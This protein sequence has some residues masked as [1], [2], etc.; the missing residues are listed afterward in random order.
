MRRPL[1]VVAAL[2]CACG[3]SSTSDLPSDDAASDGASDGASDTSIGGDAAPDAGGDG[4]GDGGA[5]GWPTTYTPPTEAT[6][7]STLVAGH[8]RLVVRDADLATIKASLTDPVAKG[9]YT[10]LVARGDA[11]LTAPVSERVLVGPR[12]LAVSREVLKRTYTLALLHRLTGDAKYLDRA[13]KELVHVAGFSD[14]NPSHFLD[15]AEMSYAFAIGYD[16]LHGSLSPA[17]RKTIADALVTKGLAE[18]KKAY[19]AK[20]W[21]T[22]DPFNWNLVCHGGLTAGALAVADEQPALA[23]FLLTRA[24]ANTP[25]AMASYAPDGAWAEGPGYWGYATQYA[26]A[27]I[28]SLKSALGT[29]FGLSALPGF[30]KAALFRLGNVGPTGLSFNFADAD[31]A[32]GDE[33]PLFWLARRFDSPLYAYGAR[34]AAGKNGSYGDLMWYDARGDAADL[35]KEPTET[36]FHVADIVSM[37]SSWGDANAVWVGFKGGDNGANHSDLDLGDFVFDALGQRWAIDLGPDNY[38]LTGYFGKER[39]TYYRKATIGQNTLLVDGKNQDEAA[40]APIT[41][42]VAGPVPWAI[43]DLS[44][45]Y[46]PLG[47]TKAQRGVALLD[48]KT[49]LLVEDELEASKGVGVVWTMHTKATVAVAGNKATLTQGGKTLTVSVLAPTTGAT[50]S[51]ADVNLAAPQNPTTGVRKL[52]IKLTGT[53][54]TR[55]AVL[56]VPEGAKTDAPVVKSLATWATAGP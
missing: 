3:D 15:V 35:A 2:L 28:A 44:K 23:K 5:P 26:V 10:A 53:T 41:G 24:I 6:V 34:G 56:F 42:F 30:S 52:Q 36:W 9:Y 48:G 50:L 54:S 47:V 29:D 31:S 51:V 20:A 38:D 39:Y 49:R 33:P 43:A 18:G 13:V 14:W 12:L 32:E 37:R 4:G 1:F 46:A 8:P 25:K 55:I 45:G 16:W 11:M 7:L 19:D 17:D 22:T 21:W 40:K 27:G